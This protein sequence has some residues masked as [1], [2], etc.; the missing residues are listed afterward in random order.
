MDQ[1]P[2]AAAR[3]VSKRWGRTS[4]LSDVSFELTSGVTALIGPNG[5]G[6]TTLISLL[7]GLTRRDGGA[8]E[9]FGRD[10]QTEGLHL[11]GDLGYSPEHHLL[12]GDMRADDFVRLMAE[13]R[14]IPPK[15]ARIRASDALWLVGLG[16]ERHRHLSTMST[17]QRQ[18]VKL[19]QAVVHSPLLV[20]LDEPTDGLDPIQRRA[21]LETIRDI[22][23]NRGID[24][25]VSTHILDEVERLC[26]RVILLDGGRVVLQGAVDEL[27]RSEGAV[28][29]SVDDGAERLHQEL[30]RRGLEVVPVSPSTLRVTTGDEQRLSSAGER[31][32]DDRDVTVEIVDA[33]A[34]LG[35]ALRELTQ[36]T[37]GLQDVFAAARTETASR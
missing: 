6:K 22:A 29:V 23:T 10:P 16:E 21:M 4:A 34:R 13:V 32:A 33:V 8:L 17:G 19:A 36:R 24:F 28:L 11:R 37:S 20:F 3:S 15:E 35:L 26:D 31:V 1:P 18:R 25:V 2:I 7:L 14:G 30:T 5:A 27:L 9:V 12:P